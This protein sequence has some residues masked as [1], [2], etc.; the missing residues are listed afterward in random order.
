MCADLMFPVKMKFCTVNC[1]HRQQIVSTETENKGGG[2][3]GGG[4]H[5]FMNDILSG[6]R[7][8][9]ARAVNVECSLLVIGSTTV[10]SRILQLGV[11]SF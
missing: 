3:T 5:T 9:D 11:Q 10:L 8:N 1:A 7:I 4:K 2:G 6:I